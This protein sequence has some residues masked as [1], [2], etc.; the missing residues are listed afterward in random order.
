MSVS[1]FS[2]YDR[3]H[4]DELRMNQQQSVHEYGHTTW[5]PSR[6]SDTNT[7]NDPASMY[8]IPKSSQPSRQVTNVPQYQEIAN[9]QPM[10]TRSPGIQTFDIP[11]NTDRFIQ[12]QQ[13]Q[14]Q[15]QQQTNDIKKPSAMR[16]MDKMDEV[17]DIE[18]CEMTK[19]MLIHENSRQNTT[20]NPVNSATEYMSEETLYEKLYESDEETGSTYEPEPYIKEGYE[21][22]CLVPLGSLPNTKNSDFGL[23]I[24]DMQP[25]I[26]PEF[27][28]PETGDKMEVEENAVFSD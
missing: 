28:T 16:E 14:L 3:H 7:A 25:A 20:S 15:Q 13:L 6:Q 22:H 26:E 17:D 18:L 10:Q 19:T 5:T 27:L 23:N 8:N 9:V 11:W 24:H 21:K 2:P 4:D 1:Q 12:P